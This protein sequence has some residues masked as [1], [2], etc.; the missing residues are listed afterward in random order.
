[1]TEYVCANCEY[2]FAGAI[3][4]ECKYAAVKLR[5]MASHVYVCRVRVCVADPR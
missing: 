3:L 4:T 2:V 5:I 1:M